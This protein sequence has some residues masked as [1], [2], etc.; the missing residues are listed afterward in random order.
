M[1]AIKN[2]KWV[3]WALTYSHVRSSLLQSHWGT[4]QLYRTHLFNVFILTN[5]S[6]ATWESFS[7]FFNRDVIAIVLA[8][9]L[10]LPFMCRVMSK[11]F[12]R[13]ADVSKS[14]STHGVPSQ[15]NCCRLILN[16][17]TAPEELCPLLAL[18]YLWLLSNLGWMHA[19]L[20]VSPARWPNLTSWL[21]ADGEWVC[22]EAD[23]PRGE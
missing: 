21:Q 3:T 15:R 18:F 7:F 13:A 5:L 17:L 20:S 14:I 4:L 23:L 9:N 6:Y 8:Q 16:H 1:M 2:A 12:Y 22:C 11:K 10:R 19:Q